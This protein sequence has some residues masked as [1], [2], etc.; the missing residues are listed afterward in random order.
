VKA[1]SRSRIERRARRGIACS[2][3]VGS[4]PTQLSREF[5][6]KSRKQRSFL[7][8]TGNWQLQHA[9]ALVVSSRPAVLQFSCGFSQNLLILTREP[10]PPHSMPA[11]GKPICSRSKVPPPAGHVYSFIF[12]FLISIVLKVN[13]TPGGA[14]VS[15]PTSVVLCAAR[16]GRRH[17]AASRQSR[18]QSY[19]GRDRIWDRLDNKN[20][21]RVSLRRLAGVCRQ[22]HDVRLTPQLL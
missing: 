6:L 18:A 15:E 14:P 20:N 3:W 5:S 13:A 1:F 22:H 12:V 4:A 16:R 2:F 11:C 19:T 21:L 10:P 7:F 8:S 9:G 17:R